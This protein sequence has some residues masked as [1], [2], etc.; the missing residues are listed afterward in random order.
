MLNC[1]I[2][3]ILI[4]LNGVFIS[5]Q[6][7][8]HQKVS[9]YLCLLHCIFCFISKIE[10]FSL[11]S[12]Y[13]FVFIGAIFYIFK[14]K[15]AFGMADY[16]IVFGSCFLIET[17]NWPYFLIFSGLFGILSYFYLKKN[18]GKFAFCP[19]VILSAII[20]NIFL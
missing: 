5:I 1:N 16:I 18:D 9:L 17:S 2:F 4:L 20:C 7:I 11:I 8:K 14:N 6:D 10:N 19:S 12:L 15:K 3:Y 13:I